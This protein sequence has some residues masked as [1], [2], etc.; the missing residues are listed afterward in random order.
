MSQ[1]QMPPTRAKSPKLGR[2][3]SS[4]DAVDPSNGEKVKG[5]HGGGGRFSLSGNVARMFLHHES[6]QMPGMEEPISTVV[7]GCGNVRLVTI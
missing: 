4:G 5:T 3:K 6:G 7:N 2:R 1:W